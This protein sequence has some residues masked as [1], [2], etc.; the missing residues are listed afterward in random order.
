MNSVITAFEYSGQVRADILALK[1][2]NAR[3]VVGPL[4]RGLAEKLEAVGIGGV[5]NGEVIKGVDVIT[6]APTTAHHL[7]Q[8]GIDQA[9]LIARFIAKQ[10]GLPCTALLR[11]VGRRTQT[12][13]SRIERLSAP[14]FVA[15]PAT[16]N[17]SILLIDDVVTTGATLLSCGHTLLAQGAVKVQMA[18]VARTPDRHIRYRK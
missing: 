1:N 11:R 7:R 15:S 8:R 6:W 10:W 5:I 9:E 17:K 2:V 18:A 12:G 13:L 4:A 16:S 3:T 14:V